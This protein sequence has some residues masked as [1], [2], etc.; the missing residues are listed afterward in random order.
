MTKYV[1]ITPARDEEAHI[2]KTILAVSEQT[3]RPAQW[4]VV[5]DGSSDSTGDILDRAAR[6]YPWITALH[7]CNRGFRQAGGGVIA[8]FN[9][10]YARLDCTDWEFLIKL[11]A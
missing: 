1:I 9:D 5:D 3:I 7:R 4:I 11:D 2:E 6:M 8:A 10:G